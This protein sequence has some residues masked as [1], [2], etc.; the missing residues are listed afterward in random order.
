MGFRSFCCLFSTRLAGP[1]RALP[2]ASRSR[3][4][5]QGRLPGG[6]GS[7]DCRGCPA[8]E[9]PY[10]SRGFRRA[11]REGCGEGRGG[12]R[13]PL[14]VTGPRVKN[15]R[16]N[17]FFKISRNQSAHLPALPAG[18]E[19]AAGRRRPSCGGSGQGLGGGRDLE[20]G[21]LPAAGDL[22]A[23]PGPGRRRC[24][25][26]TSPG[27]AA[28]GRAGSGSPALG[29]LSSLDILCNSQYSPKPHYHLLMRP[30]YSVTCNRSISLRKSL[31]NADYFICS[32]NYISFG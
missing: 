14:G 18:E 3:R 31:F 7:G 22:L 27:V 23:R 1:G 19:S 16:A 30:L 10:R 6:G 26:Q 21:L 11:T 25:P 24:P 8:K 17:G 15:G 20:A 12:R 29:F 32:H 2:S 28:C 5:P 4:S 9:W 13:G